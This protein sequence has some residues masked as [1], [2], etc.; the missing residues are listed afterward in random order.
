MRISKFKEILEELR[1]I[2]DGENEDKIPSLIKQAQEKKSE[3]ELFLQKLLNAVEETLKR[4]ITRLPNI[5]QAYVPDSFI[6]FLSEEAEKKLR[7]EKREF[8]EQGLSAILLERAAELAGTLEL[9]AKEFKVKIAVNGTLGSD[10]V[11]VRALSENA[12]NTIDKI[13]RDL[14]TEMVEKPKKVKNN[15]TIEDTGTID[16]FDAVF[17]V[18]YRVEIWRADKKLNEFPIILKQNTIGRDDGETVA[19]L[20]LQTDNR[21]ISRI[22][23]EITMEENEEIWVTALHGNPT[24][25]SGKIIRNGEKAQL[26]ADREIR[27]YD[28]LLKLK[29]KN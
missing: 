14:E 11:E 9:T 25:V 18:L 16:D 15:Q 19:N 7:R 13:T 28:F 24:V 21:K 23:A 8:F 4:E 29:F 26:G 10:E 22:H 5:N 17:D 27:I 20:R 2:I 1:R 3:S 12:Q 6:V